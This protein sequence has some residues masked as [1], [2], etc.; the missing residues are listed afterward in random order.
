MWF[1]IKTKHINAQ[2]HDSGA[3]VHL[4]GFYSVFPCR[5]CHGMFDYDSVLV[6][7]CGFFYIYIA[8]WGGGGQRM[9][10]GR[11]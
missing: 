3:F 10:G 7:L 2:I 4:C 5:G 1:Y 9:P 11:L 6:I 8:H